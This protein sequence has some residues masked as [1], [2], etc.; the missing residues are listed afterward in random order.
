[1]EAGCSPSALTPAAGRV[2]TKTRV[3]AAALALASSAT[4]LGRD[5]GRLLPEEPPA[6]LPP[7]P[8]DRLGWLKEQ[9]LG[10]YFIFLL[11]SSFK[12]RS[13]GQTR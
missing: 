4:A 11:N 7:R 6:C 3:S 2:A 5:A 9:Q 12:R 10:F 1:M 8:A 13:Q